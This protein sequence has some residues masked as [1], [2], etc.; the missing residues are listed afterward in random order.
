MRVTHPLHISLYAVPNLASF[1][2][3]FVKPY[4]PRNK[5]YLMDCFDPNLLIGGSSSVISDLVDHC[6]TLFSVVNYF[7]KLVQGI[8]TLAARRLWDSAYAPDMS[9][10]LDILTYR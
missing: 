4:N 8:S 3:K 1:P 5:A 2:T 10:F 9:A 6:S 7:I